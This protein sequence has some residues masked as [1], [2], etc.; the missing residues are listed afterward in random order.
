MRCRRVYH[1]L[2][3]ASQTAA[4][5][6]ETNHEG[7]MSKEYKHIIQPETKSN[8]KPPARTARAEDDEDHPHTLSG[9]PRRR[10]RATCLKR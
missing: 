8:L 3:N 4:R 6:V 9:I 10:P 2:P 1:P 7:P 5:S